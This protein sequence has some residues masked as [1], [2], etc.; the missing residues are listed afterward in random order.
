MTAKENKTDI[1]LPLPEGVSADEAALIFQ[2]SMN[3]LVKSKTQTKKKEDPAVINETLRKE[4][5]SWMNSNY[6]QYYIIAQGFGYYVIAHK[7]TINVVIKHEAST[8]QPTEFNRPKEFCMVSI[9]QY[10]KI[11]VNEL[12]PLI[13]M[14]CEIIKIKK[15]V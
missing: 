4:A 10:N 13:S 6:R 12:K 5:L 11:D 2:K 3:S 9:I 7:K 8:F 15:E 1:T 14:E